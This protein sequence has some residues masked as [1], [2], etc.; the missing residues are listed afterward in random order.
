MLR[1]LIT[2]GECASTSSDR[3]RH[4]ISPNNQL[5]IIS[6]LALVISALLVGCTSLHKIDMSEDQLHEKIRAGELLSEG[7]RVQI[8]TFDKKRH[9]IWV[10]GIDETLVYGEKAVRGEKEVRGPRRVERKKVS[11]TIDDIAGIKTRDF[12][13][14]KT[15]VLS[16]GLFLFF[17]ALAGAMAAAS[18]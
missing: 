10:T 8:I 16:G 2:A 4:I 12:S 14:G 7:D 9:E 11:V 13:V 5:S 1:R 6:L 3:T 15:T 18:L 17:V